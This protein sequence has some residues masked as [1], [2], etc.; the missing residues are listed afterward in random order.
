MSTQ[1]NS[2]PAADTPAAGLT[3]SPPR[4]M[5]PETA[6]Q[7]AIDALLRADPVAVHLYRWGHRVGRQDAVD[8]LHARSEHVAADFLSYLAEDEKA[9]PRPIPPLEN[10]KEDA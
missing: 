10:R 3:T 6:Q 1:P 5:S 8:Q 9:T 4:L 2:R 7:T